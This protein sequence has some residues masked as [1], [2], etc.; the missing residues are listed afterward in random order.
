MRHLG[1]VG[2]QQ[3]ADA[4]LC[5]GEQTSGHH[6]DKQQNE[7]CGHQQLRSFL[8]SSAD[9]MDNHEVGDPQDDDRPEDRP[10]RACGKRV[11]IGFHRRGITMQFTHDRR[12]DILQAP[13]RDDGIVARDQ[14]SREHTQQS[15]ILP[16][17]SSGHL[18]IGAK[19]V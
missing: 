9:A 14:E 5:A 7:E 10:H 19:G 1:E 8:Y 3:E 2:L 12:I 4:F 11:E 15:H 16:R 17:L 18:G 6:D 13:S